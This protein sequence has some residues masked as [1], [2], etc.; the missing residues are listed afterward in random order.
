LFS[1][2]GGH[3]TAAR[4]DV[5]AWDWLP[6]GTILD[7]EGW[8]G[9]FYPFDVPDL[10]NQATSA[11]PCRDRVKLAEELTLRAGLPW[12]FGTPTA[13]W[14]QA[15]AGNAPTWEGVVIKQPGHSYR[16]EKSASG[17]STTWYKMKW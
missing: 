10:A 13:A 7:G 3:Y 11:M 6:A 12:I 5:A 17:S 4:L 2:H 8:Q 15:G 14:L 9:R 16:W 1:R